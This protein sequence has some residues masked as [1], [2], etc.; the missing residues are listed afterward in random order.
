MTFN[1]KSMTFHERLKHFSFY[2][3]HWILFT[4]ILSLILIIGLILIII[5]DKKA[6]EPHHLYNKWLL[7]IPTGL[8]GILLI[9]LLLFTY[10]LY[11]NTNNMKY[12]NY[13]TTGKVINS[14]LMAGEKQD[15][16]FISGIN[17]YHIVLP[18]T[19]NVEKDNIL[20]ISSNGN[21]VTDNTQKSKYINISKFSI[22][23][24]INVKI[25]QNNKWYPI[26]AYVYDDIIHTR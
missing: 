1:E 2:T 16:T 11:S 15:V 17:K 25:K 13:N 19:V 3:D 20:K 26:D 14:E 5:S 21:F 24:K 4:I 12:I 6:Y 22:G 8:S 10:T 9:M 18:E 23:H 7:A